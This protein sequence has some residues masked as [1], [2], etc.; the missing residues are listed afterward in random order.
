M[1]DDYENVEWNVHATSDAYTVPFDPDDPLSAF[2]SS[3]YTNNDPFGQEVVS[4][5]DR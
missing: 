1:N 5:S 3:E 4:H 2:G